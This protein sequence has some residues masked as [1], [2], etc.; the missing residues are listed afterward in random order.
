MERRAVVMENVRTPHNG[1]SLSQGNELVRSLEA[2]GAQLWGDRSFEG[3]QLH[4]RVS[5]GVDLRR[6]H[7][8]GQARS[9][10]PFF[11]HS[12]M[13]RSVRPLPWTRTLGSVGVY[14]QRRERRPISGS[15]S[16]MI[17][18]TFAS[19]FPRQSPSSLMLASISAEADSTGTFP[20]IAPTLALILAL[21]ATCTL[22]KWKALGFDNSSQGWFSR[23]CSLGADDVPA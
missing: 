5:A 20:C 19:V 8:N 16:C 23:H 2:A 7:W 10:D 15:A 6:L 22:R 11:F 21:S 3:F 1:G 9:A 14:R 12:G 17:S 13:Q 18:R 4:G